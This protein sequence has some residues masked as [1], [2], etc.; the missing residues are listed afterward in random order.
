M[1]DDA[2]YGGCSRSNKEKAKEP[3]S[4]AAVCPSHRVEI[5]DFLFQMLHLQRQSTSFC[6]RSRKEKYQQQ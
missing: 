3:Y 5:S 4:L 1:V 2:V 6:G